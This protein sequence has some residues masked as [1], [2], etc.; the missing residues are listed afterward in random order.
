MTTKPTGY[1]RTPRQ[2]SA[3]GRATGVYVQPFLEPGG[4]D[5]C[6]ALPAERPEV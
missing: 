6:G 4:D 1:S 3:F 2:N 5:P